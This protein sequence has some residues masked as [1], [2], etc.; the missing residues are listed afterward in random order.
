MAGVNPKS[1]VS[2]HEKY[3]SV[4]SI[5]SAVEAFSYISVFSLLFKMVRLVSSRIHRC[6]S[7]NG[8]QGS[9]RNE[10][11]TDLVHV[12]GC[13]LFVVNRNSLTISA[14]ISPEISKEA[15]TLGWML[16][17]ISNLS[18]LRASIAAHRMF[19]KWSKMGKKFNSFLSTPT[20]VDAAIS[21][22]CLVGGL[23]LAGSNTC[24]SKYLNR[25]SEGY[26]AVCSAFLLCIGALMNLVISL[27]SLDFNVPAGIAR[28]QNL[29][30]A[31]FIMGSL[32]RFN[33]ALAKVIVEGDSL[34]PIFVQRFS[35]AADLLILLGAVINCIRVR[36]LLKN[37]HHWMVNEARG[38][39]DKPPRGL[40][41]WFKSSRSNNE[42]SD[43][44]SDFDDIGLNSEDDMRAQ[45][46]N[47][48]G[49][50]WSKV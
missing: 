22:F 24:F 7:R 35:L 44:D 31:F 30:V 1:S 32:L 33:S 42:M 18:D 10:Q 26:L 38:D 43:Y 34:P 19:Y 5:L 48:R 29:V 8:G 49:A 25:S 11:I 39:G 23:L 3:C 37:V 4:P 45:S 6:Y 46:S 14:M 36:H 20:R 27:P 41:S 50:Q 9:A 17:L 16:F 28:M 47:R 12:L 15:G 40:L 21:V 13:L 2:A